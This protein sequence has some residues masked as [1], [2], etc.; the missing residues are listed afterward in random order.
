MRFFITV[1]LYLPETKLFYFIK[2]Y[3]YLFQFNALFDIA[4]KLV[5]INNYNL[6]IILIFL[7]ILHFWEMYLSNNLISVLTNN[8]AS[9]DNIIQRSFY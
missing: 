3:S 6:Y 9:F 2:M 7:K 4:V 5:I 8:L 1:I